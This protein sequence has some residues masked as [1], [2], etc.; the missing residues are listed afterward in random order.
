MTIDATVGGVSSNSYV[1]VEEAEAYFENRAHASE[2]TALMYPNKEKALVTASSTLDWYVQWKGSRTT[3]AQSMEWP[4]SG[5]LNEFGSYFSESV[6]P[7][8]VKIAVF[9]MALSSLDT[10]RTAD[11]DLAGLSEVRAGS[12]QIKTDDGIYNTLPDTIPEKIWKIL[13]G[14]TNRGGIRSVWLY[15]A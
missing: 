15:R 3:E 13:R 8:K 11:G 5:V 2:W 4:R 10:D 14:L 7:N 1:T 12:L 9:E 6:I